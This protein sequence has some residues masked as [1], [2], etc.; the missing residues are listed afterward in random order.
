MTNCQCGKSV[1]E[2]TEAC[3]GL[4]AI[5]HR[6]AFGH[7]VCWHKGYYEPECGSFMDLTELIKSSIEHNLIHPNDKNDIKYWKA[8]I[9]EIMDNGD[10]GIEPCYHYHPTR[11]YCRGIWSIVPN[12]SA[13]LDACAELRK[14]IKEKGL[15]FHYAKALRE[16]YHDFHKYASNES[17]VAIWLGANALSVDHCKAFILA[18]EG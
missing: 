16:T 12:Y 5:V 8:R 11:D 17:W 15:E 13:S 1:E 3:R 9:K 14:V 2:H 4:D 6:V 18:M 7:I 10:C